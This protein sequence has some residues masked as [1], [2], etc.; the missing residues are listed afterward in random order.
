MRWKSPYDFVTSL[1]SRFP[2]EVHRAV[3]RS[4]HPIT[5]C[6]VRVRQSSA[7]P[8]GHGKQTVSRLGTG[9]SGNCR[10]RPFL[11]VAKHRPKIRAGNIRFNA[12]TMPTGNPV[13]L[14][15]YSA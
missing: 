8:Q 10:W 2:S 7:Q 13:R 5:C 1:R 12:V 9:L 14:T 11:I 4:K 6:S 3:K 15:Q